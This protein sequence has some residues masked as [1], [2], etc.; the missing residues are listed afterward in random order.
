L[1]GSGAQAQQSIGSATAIS[2]QV[3]GVVGGASSPLT[4][5]S[6]VYLNELVRT[7][8]D[9]QA[10]LVFLDNT[11][12]SVG[13]RPAVVLDRFVYNPSRSTGAVVV[14]ASQGVFRFVTGSQRPQNYKIITP[15]ATIGVRGTVFDLYVGADRI[16][17]TLIEGQIIVTTRQGRSVSLTQAG[18]S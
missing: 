9:G 11:N 14:R 2:N 13:P 18:E 16:V 17:V 7:G 3:E 1:F 12:L 6:S 4:L 5:G 10:R 15:V 8:V